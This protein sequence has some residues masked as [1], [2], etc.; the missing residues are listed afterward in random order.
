MLGQA[1]G[2]RCLLCKGP[3]L[4]ASRF[5]RVIKDPFSG[6]ITGALP[7]NEAVLEM[8]CPFV[9]R[10]FSVDSFDS[11]GHSMAFSPVG[12]TDS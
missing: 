2:S 4:A 10:V 3:S 7:V 11:L 8:A 6:N 1:V 5:P 9:S 12:M